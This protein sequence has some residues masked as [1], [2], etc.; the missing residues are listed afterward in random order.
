VLLLLA[1]GADTWTTLPSVGDEQYVAV[2]TAG[3]L[4]AIA[5]GA[6]MKLAPGSDNWTGLPGMPPFIDPMG[7]AV[8]ARG[9]TVYVTDHPGSRAPGLGSLF[10]IWHP[11]DDAQGFVL[12]MPAG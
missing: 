12:K 11:K 3:N 8:D 7:L 10:G 6:V 1:P 5:S 4:Y 2:D 9:N